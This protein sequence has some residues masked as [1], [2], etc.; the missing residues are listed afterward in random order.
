MAD[1]LPAGEGPAPGEPDTGEPDTS[2]LAPAVLAPELVAA[3]AVV[4][5]PRWSPDGA[6][7]AWIRSHGG[8][9][10]LVVAGGGGSEPPQVVPTD[11]APLGVRFTG[12]GVLAW[13]GSDAL[14]YAT[15]DG[16]LA[17]VG[18]GA[19]PAPARIVATAD[20]RLDAPAV[21]P[22]GRLV[23]FVL[24]ADDSCVV[25]VAPIDG[26]APHR[27][28]S[29]ADY[30][31]DPAWSPRGLLAWHEWDFPDMSWDASR[32]VVTDD[33]RDPTSRRV[34]A[35]GAGIAVGQP[36][37]RPLGFA[38]SGADELAYV[39]DE[40]GWTNVW[41]DPLGPGSGSGAGAGTDR[42]RRPVLPEPSEHAEPAWGVGQRSFAWSPAGDA[43]AIN[44]NEDGF[45]RLV[46][47]ARDGAA[48]RDWSKGWHHGLD[49]GP[50]GIACVRSGARTPAGVT[51]L[52]A[53][54]PDKK[55]RRVVDRGPTGFDTDALIEPEAVTWPSADGVTIHG[56]LWRP[57]GAGAGS[58]AQPP[59]LVDVHGGPTGEATVAWSP[60]PH[61]F[62]SRGWA[63]LQ[64]NPRGSSGSGREYLQALAGRWGELDVA[65]VAAGIRAA[66]ERGWC[67]PARVV[68]SGGSAGGFTALLVCAHHAALVRAAVVQYPVADLVELA[69]T[70]H[71]FE[72]HYSDRLVGELPRDVARYRER[73][74]I[75]H[76]ARI[77][78]PL[79]VLQGDADPVVSP[80]QVDRLVDAIRAAGG[81]VTY[82]RYPGEGHGWSGAETVADSLQRIVAFLARV[83]GP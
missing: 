83:A 30:A 44:R 10:E 78:V 4:G 40:S 82:H 64:P 23:A 13:S 72:S 26:S 75:T 15:A 73:S 52:G 51:V 50:V 24:D 79:L 54:S 81:S 33:W 34:V 39:S 71:R 49:W 43:L 20:G 45:G 35:G 57:A 58:G 19:T 42:G 32:I 38:E 1:T 11:P 46:V 31:W 55:Y 74:P 21:A 41:I 29:D 65:D 2:E 60:R 76:A 8:A 56:L 36:R 7:L 22:D 69:A 47:V 67:D 37:F 59:L 17:A 5:D 61:F 66:R 53:D 48:V 68:V 28:V 16:R 70:T 18:V 14:L 12:G 63:V 25:A 80:A 6:R 27:V 9:A 3:A 77:R 62:T